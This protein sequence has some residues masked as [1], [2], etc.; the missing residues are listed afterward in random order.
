MLRNEPPPHFTLILSFIP[1]HLEEARFESGC[2]FPQ[3]SYFAPLVTLPPLVLTRS[4]SKVE[5]SSAPSSRSWAPE[6]EKILINAKKRRE[7]LRRL[8]RVGKKKLGRGSEDTDDESWSTVGA[9]N[10]RREKG[11]GNRTEL[12]PEKEGSCRF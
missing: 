4:H 6:E 8:E 3:A 1:L 11:G 10:G 12:G 7:G 9:G 5:F 2:F